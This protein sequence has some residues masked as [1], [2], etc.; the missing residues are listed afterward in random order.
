MVSLLGTASMSSLASTELYRFILKEKACSEKKMTC[1]RGCK[2]CPLY[3]DQP[4]LETAYNQ[5]LNLIKSKDPMLYF[6][7]E[8]EEL[9]KILEGDI[10][11]GNQS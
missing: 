1:S 11:N 4:F 5:V 7:N 3:C 9:R 2:E 8:I 10:N 6:C